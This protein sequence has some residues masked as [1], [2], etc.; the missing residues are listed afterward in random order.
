[1]LLHVKHE[2]PMGIHNFIKEMQHSSIRMRDRSGIKATILKLG[3]F[4]NEN[5]DMEG[6]EDKNFSDSFRH[7]NES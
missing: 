2:S 7:I 5:Y 3:L 1:M 6:E 4:V